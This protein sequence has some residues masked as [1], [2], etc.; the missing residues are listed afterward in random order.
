MYCFNTYLL[1]TR[2]IR[3]WICICIF[4]IG[5]VEAGKIFFYK[6]RYRFALTCLYRFIKT[7]HFRL[8]PFF[9]QDLRYPD[10]HRMCIIL[11]T[12]FIGNGPLQNESKL[13]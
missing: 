1:L 8:R 6:E 9:R 3:V 13:V 11:Y 10:S 7:N 2:C 12:K 5:S 4:N